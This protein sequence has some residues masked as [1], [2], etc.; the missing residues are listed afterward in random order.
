MGQSFG[1]SQVFHRKILESPFLNVKCDC[2]NS[3]CRLRKR[4]QSKEESHH[5][6]YKLLLRFL[7]PVQHN[8]SLFCAQSNAQRTYFPKESDEESSQQVG[9]L[10]TAWQRLLGI[11]QYLFLALSTLVETSPFGSVNGH[12]SKCNSPQLPC[13]HCNCGFKFQPM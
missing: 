5:L 6:E 4:T 7:F 8:S 10:D 12:Q 2:Q 13:N 3:G 1:I 11:P 9:Q